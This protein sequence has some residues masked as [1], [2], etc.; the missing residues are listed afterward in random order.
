MLSPR[1]LVSLA[2]SSPAYVLAHELFCPAQKDFEGGASKGLVF[3]TDP[4]TGTLGWTMTGSGGVH[5]KQTFD[6]LG[7][8]VEF[9]IDTT[10]AQLGVNNNFYTSSPEPSVFP[11]YCDIQTN[12]SPVC[13]EMDIMENNGNCMS[14]VTWHTWAN[15]DGDCDQNGC[16]G[17][18]DQQ[19]SKGVRMVRT[20]FT[21]DGWM[22]VWYNGKKVEVGGRV[23]GRMVQR[24]KSRGVGPGF[25]GAD[26]W[27][28]FGSD[29]FR[30][31][32]RLV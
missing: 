9:E 30:T 13:M 27:S 23:D 16:A 29:F 15:K 6:L 3:S 21:E 20:E 25:V 14:Q 24:K 10:H 1:I 2:L 18:V 26:I 8:W 11:K 4:S 31:F 28:G 12:D 17:L 5:G 7:G 22:T 32:S 19:G